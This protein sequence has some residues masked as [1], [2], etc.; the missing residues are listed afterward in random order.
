[1]PDPETSHALIARLSQAGEAAG[2]TLETFGQVQDW[3]LLGMS[4]TASR[5]EAATRHIYLSAGIHGDEPA[6]PQ[7]I[8]ELLDEQALSATHHYYICPLLNPV[9]L[10]AGTRENADGLDLNRDYRD[11]R[12]SEVRSH[13]AWIARQVPQLDCA[14]HL[15]EDW[16]S[17]GFYLYELNFTGRPGFA[18]QIL[19]ATR[20]YLPIETAGEID[21]RAARN[22]IIRP[23]TLPEIDEGHPEAIYLQK[24][25]GG[26]NYTLETPSSSDFRLRV[27]ALKAALRAVIAEQS[28]RLR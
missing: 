18:E 25:Y 2:F 11:F 1:M 3:P 15:H 6:G 10:A 13:A 7:A 21:G 4:R 12:S 9:G 20:P 23:D 16:E 17:R 5:S 24:N 22:G 27:K 8:L 28:S 14:I 26:L 19:Q